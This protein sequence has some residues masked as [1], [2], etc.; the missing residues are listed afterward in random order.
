MKL[1]DVVRY[2]EEYLDI[3]GV[4]DY[5][6]AYNGLQVDG[7]P[8]VQR[9]ALAVDAC[10]ATIDAAADA[11]AGL[12]IVH[13]GLFWGSK[14]PLVGGL[15]RRVAGLI[16]HDIALFSAHL[17][18]DAHAEVG[19]NAVM[20]RRLGLPVAGRFAE[21]DGIPVGVIVEGPMDATE[22]RDRVAEVIGAQARLIATGPRT[23]RRI[24]I[25]S[26]GAG[27]WLHM[28]EDAGCDTFVTGE[29]PHHCYLE[30]EER[31]LNMILG[32]HYATETLGVK[33]L[34]DHLRERLALECVWI[35]HPT[36]L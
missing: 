27:T 35:D 6:D 17:P 12:L 21:H 13:H 24:G 31:G 30:A 1:A 9:V 10:Q 19:N 28:A 33:A 8:E 5:P 23:A 15:Y 26:G 14:A 25:V 34:A 16:R 18:L 2:L 3:A 7:P 22:L 20:A 11:G 32:G 4:P 29:G 36:G